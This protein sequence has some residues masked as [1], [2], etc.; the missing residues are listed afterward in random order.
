MTLE[1]QTNSREAEKTPDEDKVEGGE[2]RG[3]T[4]SSFW[5]AHAST[6]ALLCAAIGAPPDIM[7]DC[8][9]KWATFVKSSD[10]KLWRKVV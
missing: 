5:F 4:R 1:K 10:A 8:A 6:F 3:R 7:A 9:E 2:A